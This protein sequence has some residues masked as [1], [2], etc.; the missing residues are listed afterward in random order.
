VGVAVEQ[1]ATKRRLGEETLLV[2]ALSLLPSTIS[3]II[4]LTEMP[5]AGETVA[6]FPQTDLLFTV[7]LRRFVDLLFD[8]AP[9]WL[10]I[11][12]IR[13]GGENASVIG[14]QTSEIPRGIALGVP[15]GLGLAVLGGLGQAVTVAMGI[16]RFLIPIPELG[17][18]WSIPMVVLGYL[19][20]SFLEEVVVAAYLVHRL[21][22]MEWKPYLAILASAVFR[23]SYHLYQGFGGFIGNLLMGVLFAWLFVKFRKTWVLI[24]AHF[25]LD[26]SATLAYLAVRGH[27]VLGTCF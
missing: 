25:V 23:A 21:I 24:V 16:Q 11:Y 3:A 15:I 22:Q 12:L 17:H 9:V 18:W 6:L 8:F 1:R 14:M 20:T 7:A 5:I 19:A 4:S 26:G 2:L 13:R 10:A 27:C